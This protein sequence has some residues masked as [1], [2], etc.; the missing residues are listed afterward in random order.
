[1]SKQNNGKYDLIEGETVFRR[2]AKDFFQEQPFFYDKNRLWWLWSSHDHCWQMVDEID[3]MVAIDKWT[4]VESEKP[5]FKNSLLEALKKQGRMNHI[6]SFGDAA[7]GDGL[8]DLLEHLFV[9]PEGLG[10]AGA[11]H[12]RGHG[13]DLN[14]KRRQFL[15]QGLGHHLDGCLGDAVNSHERCG[16]PGSDWAILSAALWLVL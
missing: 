6:G 5:Y 4:K 8:D 11:H 13:V 2:L 12:A 7:H 14:V 16:P 15:G 9:G 10:E 1:M 3:L